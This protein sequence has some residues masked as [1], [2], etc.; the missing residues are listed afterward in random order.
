MITEIGH[1]CLVL[2]FVLSLSQSMVPICASKT[3]FRQLHSITLRVSLLNA[4]CVSFSF[5]SLV[6]AFIVSDFSVALV[7]EH[8]HSTKPMIFKI[9][10][11]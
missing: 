3:N 10:G 6:W 9:S 8:S 4:I 11:T 2:A 7:A 5:I 1:F